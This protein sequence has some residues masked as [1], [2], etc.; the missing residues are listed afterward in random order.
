M[1]RPRIHATD[2]DKSRAYRLRQRQQRD[3]M[4]RLLLQ[5]TPVGDPENSPIVDVW[6]DMSEDERDA[7]RMAISNTNQEQKTQKLA[8]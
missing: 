8:G 7:I 1:P 6:D 4:K 2:A 3:V 5:I